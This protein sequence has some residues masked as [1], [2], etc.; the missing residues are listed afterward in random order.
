MNTAARFLFAR[1]HC[2]PEALAA[3][4]A[5][6]SLPGTVADYIVLFSALQQRLSTT[7][8]IDLSEVVDYLEDADTALD[9]APAFDMEAA[10]S[11]VE[12]VMADQRRAA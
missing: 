7:Q 6:E 1:K 2:S 4:A 5:I 9:R 3:E 12:S 10:A 11:F 8:G